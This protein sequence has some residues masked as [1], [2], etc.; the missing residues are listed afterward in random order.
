MATIKILIDTDNAAFDERPSTE[1]AR[2]LR[3]LAIEYD[4]FG[5]LGEPTK[6]LYDINGNVVGEVRSTR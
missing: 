5:L 6:L 3:Q 4:D 1:V 2:I